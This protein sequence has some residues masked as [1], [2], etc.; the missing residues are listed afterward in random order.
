LITEGP[1]A[2]AIRLADFLDRAAGRLAAT[3]DL[4]RRSARLEARVL[5][6]HGLGVAPAWIVAHDR[7]PLTDAQAGLL[8]A[9]VGRRAGGEPV[10]YIVGR[11]EFYGR[12]FRVD[13][14][15]LIPRPETEHLVEAALDR[16]PA[17]RPAA[18]LDLGTGSGC[19]AVTLALERPAWR[20]TAVD[21]SPAALAV[22]ADNGRALG[23]RVEWLASDLY[24]ALP[25]RRFA[26][27]VGNP[28]YVA[29]GDPHL[30]SGDPRFEPRLA[31]ASGADGL[32]TLRAIVAG[33]PA[34]L[35]AGGWL[36]LEHGWDQGEAVA[37][38]LRQAGFT[39]VFT[40]RDLA[41]RARVSGGR[42]PD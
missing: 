19:V 36:I 14:A 6:A 9:L 39:A 23:A 20:L 35:E 33:A 38:L 1:T 10:A 18:V 41:G 40:D 21:V 3:L 27:I 16:L 37:G 26:A 34:H 24:A 29:A 8:E 25:G 28:P 31:L 30:V 11:R 22:A 12:A 7:D 2:G 17:D 32:D 13:P 42:R 4:D 15:V 5:A